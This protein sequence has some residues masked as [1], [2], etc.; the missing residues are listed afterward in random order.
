MFEVRNDLF[1]N[2]TCLLIYHINYH[3]ML[4]VVSIILIYVYFRLFSNS[5]RFA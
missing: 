3:K 2:M 1:I 5:T 4:I